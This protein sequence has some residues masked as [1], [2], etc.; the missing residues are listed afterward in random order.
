V[1][2]FDQNSLAGRAF[3]NIARRVVGEDVPL[4]G[5]ADQQGM[6]DRLFGLFGRKS[7]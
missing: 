5:L 6:L 4:L 3:I 7:R 2:V 1:A